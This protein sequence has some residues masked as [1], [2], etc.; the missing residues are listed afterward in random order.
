MATYDKSAQIYDLLY[1][2]RDYSREIEYVREQ[3]HAR[4][5]QARTLLDLACGTGNHIEGLQRHFEVEGLD[6]S[7]PMLA[8]ARLKF[9]RLRFHQASM[10]GFALG[11]HFD[12][13]CCL[14][15]SIAFARTPEGLGATVRAAA[16]HLGP[17]GLLLIEPFFTPETF[18]VGHVVCH[19]ARADDLVVQ[20]MHVSDRRGDL[21]CFRNHFL[22]G[23]PQG[24]EH[25]T[26]EQELGLFRPGDFARAFG[27]AGLVLEHDPDGPSGLGLYVGSKPAEGEGR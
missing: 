19:E 11:R 27:E 5:P 10:T 20:W 1:R 17:G 13:V 8:Q 21:G 4:R 6:L 7:E 18:W 12:V 24:I 16:D 3:V 14:F 9:P 23:R 25:F 22:V 26:E 2:F 15:R